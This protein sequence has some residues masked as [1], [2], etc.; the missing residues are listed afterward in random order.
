[1]TSVKYIAVEKD[2]ENM[3]FDRWFKNH[4]PQINFVNL[5][6]ILRS[7]QIR[8][9]KKRVKSNDRI[10]SGQVVRIPPIV[11]ALNNM[12]KDEKKSDFSVAKHSEFLKSILLYADSHIY[13]FN[14]PAGISVQGGSGIT[15]HI[16]GFLQSW[17]DSKLQKPRLIHRLDQDTSGLLVVARTR[18]AAQNLTESFRMRRIKKIYW[19]LVWGVPQN[20]KKCISNWLL[21]KNQAGGDYVRVVNPG[22]KGA[23]HAI[24]Y[25]KII[26]SFA[27]KFCWLEMQPY[28]GRTHQL[29]VHALHM[30]YPIVG[31][32]KYFINSKGNFADCIQKKLYLHARY[33]DLPHPEGG[34]LQ[35]TAPLPEHMVETWKS[36]GFQYKQD[37][38]FQRL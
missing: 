28:T 2:E 30:G 11:N 21:K 23:N 15:N 1:M 32:K 25:F 6:R 24:S 20:K 26:D 19:S 17:A 5:Q 31:D 37:L 22:E 3:R 14:K 9:D 35:I 16:D 38:C 12:I 34:R 27:Q 8:L 29:R 10:Q 33:I 7:G 4:Y 18:I 36:F 13:V